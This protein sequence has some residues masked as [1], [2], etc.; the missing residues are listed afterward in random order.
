MSVFLNIASPADR[1]RHI[2]ETTPVDGA[3]GRMTDADLIAVSKHCTAICWAY[4]S[5]FGPC[6]D[7]RREA[8]IENT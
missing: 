5:D 6:R 1:L 4:F 8:G 2:R 3:W 7:C